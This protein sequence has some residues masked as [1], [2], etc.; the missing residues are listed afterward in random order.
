MRE[1]LFNVRDSYRRLKAEGK[2]KEVGMHFNQKDCCDEYDYDI[3]DVLLKVRVFPKGYTEIVCYCKFHILKNANPEKRG[4]ECK[5]K[6]ILRLY[7]ISKY[8]RETE[9]KNELY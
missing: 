7:L 2:I 6:N 9:G 3:A 4:S 8:S 5:L 1:Q